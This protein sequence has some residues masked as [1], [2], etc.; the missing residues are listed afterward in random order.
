ARARSSEAWGFGAA[1]LDP[2]LRRPRGRP[3]HFFLDAFA[4]AA[5]GVDF[6]SISADSSRLSRITANVAPLGSASTEKRPLFG[7][8]SGGLGTRPPRDFA[9]CTSP[10]QSAT[11]K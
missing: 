9:R 6:A 2:G 3:V 7:M 8:S 4:A 10:S 11:V 1:S 5:D